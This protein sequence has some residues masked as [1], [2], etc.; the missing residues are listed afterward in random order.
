MS[1]QPFNYT[2]PPP[3]PGY[4]FQ[5]TSQN[6]VEIGKNLICHACG[7]MVPDEGYFQAQHDTFHSNVISL[8]KEIAELKARYVIQEEP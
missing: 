4:G 2:G 6:G 7:A 1:S 3:P 8:V 5:I